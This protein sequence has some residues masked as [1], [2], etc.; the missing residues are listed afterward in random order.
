MKITTA[1]TM[2]CGDA[3]SLVVDTEKKTVR[4]NPKHPFTKGFCCKKGG[5]YF[6]R[7]GSEDRITEPLV[8]RGSGFEP[9]SWDEA[10]AL[11]ADKLDA[12]RSVPESILHIHGHGYRGILGKASTVFFE[13]LGASTHYGCL[14]DDTGIEAC[15]RD[16]GVLNHNDPEDI[17][18]A[19]RVVNWGRDMTRC[20][21]HQLALVQKA[22]KN[23]TEVLTISPGGDGTPE[24]SDVNVMI[25]PGTDRFLAAAVLKL[26]LEAGDLNPWVLTRTANWP[27][28]RGL[29]DGL[30]FRDLC[31]AC[32]VPARDAEM[33]YEWYADRGAVATV[34]GWGLQR[35]VY[36]GE[37]VRFINAVAMVSGQIGIRGGGSYFNISSGRNLGDWSHLVEGGVPAGERRRLLLQDLGAELAKADPPV[38]FV[39][40]D[41][42][43]VVN[44]IP[45]GLALADALAA[46][47]VV[48]VEAVM[49]DTAMR[50]DV[51]LPPALMFEREDVLGSFV[52]NYVNRCAEVVPP[53][54]NARHDFDIMAELGARLRRPVRFPDRERCLREGLKAA[55][56]SWDELEENGFARV[57]HPVVAFEDLVFGHLD[58]L[59]RFP[60]ALH[61]EPPRDPDYPL[62]LLTLVRGES[63]HSQIPEQNMRGVPT[64]WISKQN[65]AFGGLNPAMDVYLTTDL[66]AMQVRVETVEDLHPRTV[67]M[68]RGGWMKYGHGANA[69]IAPSVTDMA[70]GTA[71]YSQSCR[72]ENR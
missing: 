6:E 20:S 35:H 47:F 68:R 60:E 46:P 66:G 62:Q 18:N 56:I 9:V 71:Y 40:I 26:F 14:C 38:D 12:A 2:D 30:K 43:N 15:I 64:V 48:A 7:I 39:W 3:C 36:G 50:A 24:F 33:V 44:Q 13:K 27:A 34:M 28:L 52:H 45:D 23:G 67:I 32:E 69:I 22:R 58:G 61:P 29:V 63:L 42:H 51:I 1:C 57:N 70:H 10:M 16:F 54:G 8:R 17:L 55:N 49:N 53:R 21:I 4:G 31:A 72:L 41:G 59:Y 5:R 19:D 37:N 11:V 65:P 25:R